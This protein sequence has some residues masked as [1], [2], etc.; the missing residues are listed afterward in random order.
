MTQQQTFLKVL[1]AP[2]WDH[3]YQFGPASWLDD[4]I[5]QPTNYQAPYAYSPG[6]I[7]HSTTGRVAVNGD[8]YYRAT[9]DVGDFVP[10]ID[11]FEGWWRFYEFPVESN[12][13][14]FAWD[15]DPRTFTSTG[16]IAQDTA[17]INSGGFGGGSNGYTYTKNRIRLTGIPM[18]SYDGGN[19]GTKDLRYYSGSNYNYLG[20]TTNAINEAAL[21]TF[22]SHYQDAVHDAIIQGSFGGNVGIEKLMYPNK[23]GDR[24]SATVGLGN[25]AHASITYGSAQPGDG[26]QKGT[27]WAGPTNTSASNVHTYG[28]EFT[29]NVKTLTHTWNTIT[30][31]TALPGLSSEKAS[32]AVYDMAQL[33]NLAIDMGAMRESIEVTGVIDDSPNGPAQQPA[34]EKW[35]QRQ[36]LMDIAR[37]QWGATIP[38]NSNT[39]DNTY[40]NPNRFV[41]LTIGPMY[42]D[43]P[44]GD[45]GRALRL[46][47]HRTGAFAVGGSGSSYD[48]PKN[49]NNNH[50][51]CKSIDMWRY[52]DEPHDD[53]RGSSY[54][55]SSAAFPH[56][57]EM[58]DYTPNYRGRR[59]YRGQIK[60]LTFSLREGVP[61]IWEFS[62]TLDVY[63]NESVFRRSSDAMIAANSEKQP[64]ESN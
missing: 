40:S 14:K 22:P 51:D 13:T 50:V 17:G 8:K 3:N 44:H 16:N 54:L 20:S 15:C 37:G 9:E 4:A 41:A 48:L 12:T 43:N 19:I 26:H 57:K 33:N 47:P 64:E 1:L 38:M 42:S 5:S 2:A 61:D 60:N 59:R 53:M 31:V 32:A 34:G 52:G 7:G 63:K 29:L 55:I 28:Y 56:V 46:Y 24:A 11:I 45:Q 49:P 27:R 10:A 21:P 62:F 35:I 39:E 18:S 6:K 23:P 25:G 36:Q 58:W 30:S